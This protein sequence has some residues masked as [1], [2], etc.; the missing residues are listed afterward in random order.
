MCHRFPLTNLCTGLSSRILLEGVLQPEQKSAALIDEGFFAE[1]FKP[2]ELMLDASV[3]TISTAKS[4][5]LLNKHRRF[6]GGKKDSDCVEKSIAGL[7]EVYDCVLLN[8][9]SDLNSKEKLMEVVRVHRS[10]V[11]INV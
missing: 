1:V 8:D 7:V 2:G 11:K 9:K 4:C 10:G 5:Q 6:L 3:R